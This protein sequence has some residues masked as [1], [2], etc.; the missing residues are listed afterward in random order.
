MLFLSS[1]PH[2]EVE[3]HAREKA[4]FCHAQEKARGEEASHILCHAQQGCHYPPGKREC[5][6]PYF[7]GGQLKSDI[8]WYL[9][10]LVHYA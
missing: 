3:D 10:G 7:G 9:S 4:T 6:K 8:A 2:R 5:R 1:V